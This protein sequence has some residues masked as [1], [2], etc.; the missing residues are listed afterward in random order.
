ML[1]RRLE[2]KE[3]TPL[4]KAAIEALS[5]LS[6]GMYSTGFGSFYLIC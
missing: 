2:G 1:I 6:A 5:L 4:A 3:N